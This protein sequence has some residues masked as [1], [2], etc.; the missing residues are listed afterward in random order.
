MET[1]EKGGRIVKK[2]RMIGLL[3]LILMIAS[4]TACGKKPAET[5]VTTETMKEE[6]P[7]VEEPTVE[8]DPEPETIIY[9]PDEKILAADIFDG[10]IQI[11]EHV[12]EF[13]IMFED[14]RAIGG[15]IA[16]ED[17]T[18][19]YLMTQGDEVTSLKMKFP[20]NVSL[21]VFL[22]SLSTLNPFF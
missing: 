18:E 19:N 15:E 5:I 2:Y 16:D 9:E 7:K 22:L 11:N 14:L 21:I 12:L 4:L 17:Y 10:I 20:N 13:P 6:T 8:E 1:N 3:A